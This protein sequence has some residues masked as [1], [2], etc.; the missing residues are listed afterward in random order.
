LNPADFPKLARQ[1]PGISLQWRPNM[2]NYYEQTVIQ[3]TIPDNDM[4]PLERLLLS[5]IFQSELTGDGWY[6]FAEENPCT[7]I[8]VTR[9]EIKAALAETTDTGSAAYIYV[10]GKL[11]GLTGGGEEIE[12][13]LS[14]TSWEFFLQDI[15]KRSKTL[16]YITIATAFTCS[17]MRL[18]GFGGM[19]VLITPDAIVGK[20][21]NDILEELLAEA[22]LDG[23]ETSPPVEVIA[24][25]SE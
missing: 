14:G 16:D 18:D 11:A 2:A 8:D 21:T 17:T 1:L 13:D 4:T 20:S 19:A 25:D 24:T 22:G 23:G 9:S 12:L 15:V 3:Q 5:Q 7:M 6:L 10:A